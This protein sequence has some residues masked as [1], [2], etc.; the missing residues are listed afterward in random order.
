[1]YYF[2]SSTI[3]MPSIPP[4]N[5]KFLA[6]RID[7]SGSIHALGQGSVGNDFEVGNELTVKN[8]IIAD[9]DISANKDLIVE[10]KSTFN[11]DI[12]MN[13]HLDARDASFNNITVQ[14]NI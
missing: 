3:Y 13:G 12:S 4:F 14:N 11:D 1:M 7:I 2:K 8:K 10:G 9:G 6:N 5:L